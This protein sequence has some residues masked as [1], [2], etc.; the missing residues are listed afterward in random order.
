MFKVFILLHKW[1][2]KSL[3]QSLPGDTTDNKKL[4]LDGLQDKT[5]AWDFS[6]IKQEC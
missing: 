1:P 6:N 4:C 5:G 2:Q 3:S